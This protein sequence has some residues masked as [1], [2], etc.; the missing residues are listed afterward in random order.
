MICAL[1]C[2]RADPAPMGTF[3]GAPLTHEA[4]ESIFIGWMAPEQGG[5]PFSWLVAAGKNPAYDFFRECVRV[6]CPLSRC[7]MTAT[8]PACM[9]KLPPIPRCACLPRAACQ[10]QLF[11]QG[12]GKGQ[13][14][15][16]AGSCACGGCVGWG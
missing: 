4:A 1:L 2:A 11:Y 5:G 7:H 14:W 10:H 3:R 8:S 12:R 16:V 15:W 6:H 13:L 9:F